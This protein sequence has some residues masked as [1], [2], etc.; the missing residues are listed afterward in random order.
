MKTFVFFVIAY[1]PNKILTCWA[2]QNDRLYLSFLKDVNVVGVK[3]TR[4]S[5]KM[6]ITSSTTK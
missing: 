1:D 2:L 4:N 6:P 5:H 3:M